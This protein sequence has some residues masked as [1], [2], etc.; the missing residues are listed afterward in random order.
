M[1]TI[2][3]L[4]SQSKN[5]AD[6]LSWVYHSD[7]VDSLKV[8]TLIAALQYYDLDNIDTSFQIARNVLAIAIKARDTSIM[9]DMQFTIA[10]FYSAQG[11]H[12]EALKYDRRA[13][14]YMTAINDS[15]GIIRALNG[16][17]VDYWGMKLYKEAFSYYLQAIEK[18]EEFQ[19][20]LNLA[21]T[22]YNVGRVFMEVRQYSNSKTFLKSSLDISKAIDDKLGEAYAL[23]DLAVIYLKEGDSKRAL[24]SLQTALSIAEEV[25]DNL[26]TPQIL[27]SLAKYYV[28][29]GNEDKAL[30][31]YGKAA[32]IYE[33]H[34]NLVELANI[35]LGKGRI[36]A[37]RGDTDLAKSYFD[38]ALE[39]GLRLNDAEI[40][41]STY[42]ELSL[43]YEAVG[44]SKE[45]LELL[46]KSNKLKDSLTNHN[47]N[48]QFSQTLLEYE[49][50]KKDQAIAVLNQQENLRQQQLKNEEFFRNV[51][52]VILALTALLLLTLYR[53]S[54]R[55]KRANE[56]LLEH[57]KEIEAKSKELQSLLS[58]K[59]K[60]F[61]IVSHDL[62]SP[63]NGLVGI[64][65]MLDEGQVSQEE[66]VKLSKSLR[67]RL[68]TTRKMLDN[69]LDW[70]LV[71]MNE[72]T[73]QLEN[74]ELQ[75]IVDENL[76]FFKELNEKGIHFI[77][78]VEQ[79]LTVLADKNMLDL[80]FRNL[81]ANSIKFSE[82]GG[83]IEIS[84]EEEKGGFCRIKVSDD[85]VGMSKDQ[86]NKIFDSSTLYTTRGTA[87]ERGTGLGLKLCKEFVEKMGGEIWVES[88][89]GK[90]STFIFTLKVAKKQKSTDEF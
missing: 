14:E 75:T 80:I 64:M 88:R 2:G 27:L 49:I 41:T 10:T 18:A 85:G 61:S 31:Y 30:D 16:L 19:D 48:Q 28:E 84:H 69:L 34:A 33:T 65:D 36:A 74:L 78:A 71:E 67:V 60:F 54:V 73:L 79:K 29:L 32:I 68:D 24:E 23:N 8:Q 11:K 6:S 46:K 40:L 25:N 35:Q 59:D 9:A 66:L 86:V 21:I 26:L 70:A 4:S 39:T 1:C 45:S 51:L 62:R 87:N 17:G 89:S 58:M 81:V 43:W 47:I 76:E 42:A 83:K 44:R 50:N 52:V 82:N 55:R 3:L 53:S 57:Q 63:I 38:E 13:Y 72:I 20:S 90:G 7:I 15:S 5:Y 37:S 12:N 77:N 22:T 56:L